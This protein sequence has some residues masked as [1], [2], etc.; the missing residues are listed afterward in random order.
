[1]IMKG[2]ADLLSVAKL[3]ADTATDK[4]KAT[5]FDFERGLMEA[6]TRAYADVATTVLN[7]TLAINMYAEDTAQCAHNSA[8]LLNAPGIKGLA[9]EHAADARATRKVVDDAARENDAAKARARRA[10]QGEI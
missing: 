9:E 6:A 7:H 8:L 2:L 3:R 10:E 4:F 5:G 1:M